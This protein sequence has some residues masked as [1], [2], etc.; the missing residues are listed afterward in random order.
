MHFIA[1]NVQDCQK[2]GQFVVAVLVYFT[3]NWIYDHFQQQHDLN[4]QLGVIAIIIGQISI[5]KFRYIW[6]RRNTRPI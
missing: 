6:P 4:T 2:T 1:K 5:E 3:Q